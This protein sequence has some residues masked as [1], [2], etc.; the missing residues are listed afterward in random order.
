MDVNKR[1]L[2]IIK[3]RVPIQSVLDKDL[4]SKN[5]ALN[6]NMRLPVRSIHGQR[7]GCDR[8]GLWATFYFYIKE[9][10]VFVLNNCG[11]VNI[12]M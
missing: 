6:V 7:Y 5:E 1:Q 11:C 9:F 2:Q 10:V 8:H 4:D 12:F 3:A